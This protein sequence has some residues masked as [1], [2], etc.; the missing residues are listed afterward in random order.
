MASHTVGRANMSLLEKV[1]YLADYI[2]PGRTTP[3]IEAVRQA[4]EKSLDEGLFLALSNTLTWLLSE[5]KVIHPNSIF[6][7]N[8]LIT[9]VL[10]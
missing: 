3:G 1:V 8:W 5:K 7:Y 10:N 6:M 2:E 4:T 9:E